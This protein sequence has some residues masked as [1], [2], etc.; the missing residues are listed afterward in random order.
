VTQHEH[1]EQTSSVF[2]LVAHHQLTIEHL[3]G[4]VAELEKEID[5]LR[6][7]R[8]L[9]KPKIPLR[10]KLSWGYVR[11]LLGTGRRLLVSDLP[12]QGSAL[13]QKLLKGKPDTHKIEHLPSPTAEEEDDDQEDESAELPMMITLTTLTLVATL[14]G[15]ASEYVFPYAL[16]PWVFYGIAFLNGAYYTVQE[17]WRSIKQRQFDVNL[18]MILA[19]LGAAIIGQPREGAMLMFLFS[20]SATLETYAMRRTRMGIQSLLDMTPTTARVLQRKDGTT[21]EVEVPVEQVNVGDTILVRPGEQI[22]TDGVVARGES[23]VN[24]ATITGE[25]MPVEKKVDER[26]FGGTL[27]E[28]GSLEVKV[29]TPVDDSVLARIVKIVREARHRKARSQD[30]TD[31]VIGQYYAYTV[32]GITALA[33]VIPLVFLGQELYSTIYRAIT[34]MVVASPCALVI[35]IPSA[36]LSALASAAH[37]GVLFKGGIHLESASQVKVVAFD[38]TGTLTTGQPGI[39]AIIPMVNRLPEVVPDS[40]HQLTRPPND[41]LDTLNRNQ[42]RLLAAT[43][44]VEHLSEH[45]LARAIVRCANEHGVVIPEADS[46]ESLAGSGVRARVGSHRL[47]VGRASLFRRSAN[48]SPLPE[49]VTRSIEEQEQQGRSVIV[50]GNE[51]QVW[52][53]IAIADTTRPESASVVETLKEIGVERTVLLT[54]DNYHVANAI[55][56]QLGF[57]EVYAELPPEGKVEKLQQLVETHGPVAMIG[58]GVNDAP[59]LATATLG[60]AMGA[61]GTDVALESADV[62]LMSDELSH[63]PGMFHLAKRSRA[64]IRQ[65]LVF[66]FGV[67]LVLVALTLTISLPLTVGV[68]GHEGSTLIVVANGLRLL[69]PWYYKN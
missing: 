11:H 40:R 3:Q 30:F 48:S 65:N 2:D 66:A 68:I 61:A 4:R 31:R 69:A 1:K 35:S 12:R 43:A 16:V 49:Q 36:I 67:M 18:L 58:D 20:L 23:T 52:G 28:Q 42:V 8:K 54:G 38:K 10:D 27:N 50:V 33:V 22:P 14:L 56:E 64:V 24:E 13:G 37:H 6:T 51:Q 19:A 17:A 57:D 7:G 32:V 46:F 26:V 9:P 25:S 60:V 59:A 39:V 53:I 45:P 29:T 41:Q 21:S 62:L 44:A 5:H 63:L 55:G 34:L 15:W 47:H